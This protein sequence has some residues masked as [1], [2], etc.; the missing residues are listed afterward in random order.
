MGFVKKFRGIFKQFIP[1]GMERRYILKTYAM[2]EPWDPA[3]KGG[4]LGVVRDFL[5][6]GLVRGHLKRRYEREGEMSLPF[7]TR[8]K[9]LGIRMLRALHLIGEGRFRLLRDYL[10]VEASGLFDADWYKAE[11]PDV[12]KSRVDPLW[13]Y[14]SKGWRERRSP[15]PYF[16]GREYLRKN[17]DVASSQVNPVVHFVMCGSKEGRH[18]IVNAKSERQS[19]VVLELT[20]LHY[21][22]K[23]SVIVASYNYENFLPETLDSLLAQTY[24]NFEVIVVDDGSSDRSVAV[25]RKYAKKHSNVFLYQHK[26]GV[27]RGLPATVKL[28]LSKASGEFVAFCESDDIWM[29]DH[30]LAKVSLLNGFGTDSP[31]IVINDIQP[32]GDEGRSRAAAKVAEESMA[33][34]RETRNLVSVMDFRQRNW[35]CTFSCCMVRR[36]VL[37]DCDFDTCPRPANLDWWL[38]RQICCTNPIYVV[39][40]KLTKWRMHESFMAKESVES[41][42]LNRQ[43]LDRMDRLLLR[44]HP[45]EA[46]ELRRIVEQRDRFKVEN[47]LLLD[48]GEAVAAQPRFSVVMPTYNRA[49]CIGCAIDS[50][51]RQTYQNF[52]LVIAD[53]GSTDGT[54][55]LVRERYGKELESGRIKYHHISNRGV[56][57]ARNYALGHVTGD[58]I[59]YLDSDNEMCD[60]F[61]EEFAR[62]IIC[63]PDARNFYAKLICRSSKKKVGH[64]FDLDS[65]I[66]ANYIDLGVYVHHRS[67]LDEVGAFDENMTRLVD[68]DLIVRQAKA[69]E[70]LFIDDIVLI[71]SDDGDY[72]RITNSVLLKTNMD[73]FRKKH[74]NWP[75][76]TTIITT[77]NHEKYIK[78][79]IESAIMQQGDFIHEIIVSS[80]A[81]TDGTQS[82]IDSLKE[83]YPGQFKDLSG[84]EN[85][86]IS[87]NLKRCFA[88]ATGKYIAIL[89]GDDYWI[90]PW[91]INR[92][93]KFMRTH[94]KCSMCFSRIKL[95]NKDGMFALLPRQS[96]LPDILTGEDFIRDPNQNLIA[97]FSCCLFDGEIAKS[98]PDILY[99]ERFTEIG[100]AFFIEQ[101]GP[102]GFLPDI[103]SVYRLHEN[104]VWSACDRRRQLE[105][106]IRTRD[107]ALQVCAPKYR[108]RMQ[109]IIDKLKAQLSGLQDAEGK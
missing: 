64:A 102:I 24:T 107:V 2:T 20:A 15:G 60:Y 74:C 93:V 34:L 27:N 33:V 72:G 73:Y 23:I 82:V 43:F 84:I 4:P 47:G 67:L 77:Y 18:G 80:D 71:Y 100:C 55:K 109:A 75:T 32:F 59:A 40:A 8:M 106:A 35:I 12:V 54:E 79:A 21:R 56:C 29:P 104:G 39:R 42:L 7:F 61:L 103:M 62:E 108:E 28:G 88:A 78:R 52:E 38:W 86:G 98:F 30:L 11:Y 50:L 69:S 105:S 46:K 49:F 99:S 63:H 26:G 91:K 83:L 96:G 36:N 68:W 41:I 6:Y 31:A 22:P 90:T 13:H 81:S 65:L 14:C 101:K 5:P 94:P 25:A 53:D 87:A 66:K 89:E 85:V 45:R 44:R 10:V 16:D 95:L 3:G 92:Q 58:W 17:R 51:L 97:N 9:L 37:Q 76:V 1:Y 70:P 57:K 19:A 48:N